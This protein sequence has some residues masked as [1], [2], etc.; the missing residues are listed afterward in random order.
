[1]TGLLPDASRVVAGG[2]TRQASVRA[3]LEHVRHPRV[4]V[5]DAARPFAPREV[6]A[7]VVRA[8]EEADAAVPG[9]QMKETVKVVRDRRVVKTL[10]R[11][12]VWNI[13]TP[14]AFK[15]DLLRDLHAR[16][17]RD[18]VQGTDDAQLIEHYGGTVAV[19]EGAV[20]GF[21][22]TDADDVARAAAHARE[23]RS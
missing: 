9:L 19:V 15:T 6:F 10:D 2:V 8:L 1:M 23:L 20:S 4:V 11:E 7:A 5:H 21:K 17:V 16:A 22:V 18:D 13:Q 3:G 14:Q 12:Q